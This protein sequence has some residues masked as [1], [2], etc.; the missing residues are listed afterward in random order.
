MMELPV[1]EQPIIP[2]IDG[3]TVKF[4]SDTHLV[5]THRLY[6]TIKRKDSGSISFSRGVKIESGANSNVNTDKKRASNGSYREYSVQIV[7]GLKEAMDPKERRR[8][9]FAGLNGMASHPVVVKRNSERYK[10]GMGTS[11]P[12]AQT[13]CGASMLGLGTQFRLKSLGGSRAQRRHQYA[14][15]PLNAWAL[16]L[17]FNAYVHWTYKVPLCKVLGSLIAVF[18]AFVTVFTILVYIF[19]ITE[20]ECLSV[21]PWDFQNSGSYFIDAFQISWTTFSTVGYGLAGPSL[22]N[23]KRCFAINLLMAAEAFLGV[24]YA[25]VAGAILMGKIMRYN[26]VAPLKWSDPLVLR[27]GDGVQVHRHNKRKDGVKE[28]IEFS[29]NESHMG[30]EGHIPYPIIELRVGNETFSRNGGEIANATVRA[31]A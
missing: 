16:A 12:E 4:P 9:E 11:Y 6:D 29:E 27:Y 24:S 13:V 10:E 1:G 30:N 22:S 5:E 2:D 14:N 7:T 3:S 31:W 25:G 17:G 23:D 21:G 20:P 8:K 18:L 19:G 28:N 15:D 26:A